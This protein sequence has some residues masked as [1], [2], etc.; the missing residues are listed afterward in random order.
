MHTRETGRAA[1]QL[2]RKYYESAGYTCAAE[3]FTV[4]WWELDLVMENADCI[5]CVEVK[6][7]S[8]IKDI[9]DYITPTKKRRIYHALQTYVWKYP[10]TKEVRC[11][12]VFVSHGKIDTVIDNCIDFF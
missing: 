11:D 3:N 8:M 6:D 9:H 10:T 4:K 2:V 12:V 5:V 7:V 1:E